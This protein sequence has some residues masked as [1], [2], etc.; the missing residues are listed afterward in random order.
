MPRYLVTF[1]VKGSFDVAAPEDASLQALSETFDASLLEM[2]AAEG[3]VLTQGLMEEDDLPEDIKRI[4]SA[5][6]SMDEAIWSFDDGI[7]SIS[8][9]ASV[10]LVAVAND[11]DAAEMMDPPTDLLATVVRAIHVEH[12]DLPEGVQ[13][14]TLV[15]ERDDWEVSSVEEPQRR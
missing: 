14:G 5:H 13:T 3:R 11:M 6:V 2:D 10:L 7:H 9:F 8:A 12:P 15:I 1:E 4:V